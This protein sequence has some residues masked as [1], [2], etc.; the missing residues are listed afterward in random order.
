MCFW[1]VKLT[2]RIL[3]KQT[4]Q[5]IWSCDHKENTTIATSYSSKLEHQVI[6]F[7]KTLWFLRSRNRGIGQSKQ[8]LLVNTEYHKIYCDLTEEGRKTNVYLVENIPRGVTNA[9]DHPYVT[10]KH[11]E[12]CEHVEAG[13]VGKQTSKRVT[14]PPNYVAEQFWM[15]SVCQAFANSVNI[16]S[17][18]NM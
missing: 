18:G 8:N 4:L 11:P 7:F 10:H 15:T 13:K 14:Y 1:G 16:V 17:T 12:Q 3:K 9:W 2:A 5:C 6:V